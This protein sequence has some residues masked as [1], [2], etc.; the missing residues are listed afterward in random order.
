MASP[1]TN[2]V[3]VNSTATPTKKP[4]QKLSNKQLAAIL[5][6]V[7][8]LMSEEGDT[9]KGDSLPVTTPNKPTPKSDTQK[10]YPSEH[11]ARQNNPAQYSEVRRKND[12][13]GPGISVI[14]GI[15][16]GKTEVQSLRFAADKFTVAEATKWLTDHKYSTGSL[17][18]ASDAKPVA[19][20]LTCEN[21]GK[22][23]TSD[24]QDDLEAEDALC[25]ACQ[26]ELAKSETTINIIAKADERQIA[27][28]VAYPA[29]PLGWS[30]TQGDW[31][32]PAEIELMAHNY[33]LKSRQ[34]DINH[35]RL[36]SYDEAQIV[37]SYIA[38]A[39]F[40]LNDHAVTKGSWVVA[41]YFP[42]PEAWAAV[43]SGKIQAYSIK[44]RG[45]RTRLNTV[46]TV[47]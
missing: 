34:Y 1:D 28:G 43:K 12:A 13:F 40:T 15:K 14:Y 26:A 9:P 30:D 27:Y 36:A 47:D 42:R 32:Q 44:G 17:E 37:E 7:A 24:V 16:D 11:A 29:K 46:P 10:P 4:K 22:D 25:P 8:T 5:T 41:T 31:I 2:D 21:C 20:Q 38:P 23:I 45:K 18:P 39:D 3:H 19:K 6:R 33:M 35:A